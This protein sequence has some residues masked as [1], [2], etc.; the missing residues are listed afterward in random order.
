MDSHFQHCADH[1]RRH[2]YGRYISCLFLEQQL[3]Q[4]AFAIY[5]F[6]HKICQIPALISDPMPG[7]IRIQ[8]WM[9]VIG[10]SAARSGDPIAFALQEVITEYSLP[11][12]MLERLLQAHIFDL[13]NDPMSDKEVLETYLGET[14]SSL[15]M[16]LTL[17]ADK[18]NKK[19]TDRNNNDFSARKFNSDACGHG[20]V[21]GGVVDLLQALPFHEHRE[22]CYF[23]Q[24]LS[25]RN[26]FAN[27]PKTAST[28]CIDNVWLEDICNYA[29]KHH[30]AATEAVFQLPT[31]TRM[32]FSGMALHRLELDR[33][34]KQGIRLDTIFDPPSRLAVIWCLWKAKRAL[35]KNLMSE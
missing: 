10:N 17:I 30:K 7:E 19:P 29:L 32:L 16:L 18:I 20:G 26:R 33:I 35:A 15:F 12:D 34:A 8:W 23:P 13:Y 9:D 21:F 6:H 24:E 28:H 25:I 4:A 14:S 3:R 31:H 5:A 22:Q 27:S 2:D 1:L 11:I